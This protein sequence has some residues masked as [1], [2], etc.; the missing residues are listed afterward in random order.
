MIFN[1]TCATFELGI[2]IICNQSIILYSLTIDIMIT[3]Y[4]YSRRLLCVFD[5]Y[6]G[7]AALIIIKHWL[8]NGRLPEFRD[9]NCIIRVRSE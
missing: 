9:R 6:A 2:P 1:Q 5:I 8:A 3:I 7:I 4:A